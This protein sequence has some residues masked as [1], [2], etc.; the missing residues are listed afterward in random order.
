AHDI[1]L[2][3]YWKEGSILEEIKKPSLYGKMKNIKSLVC[4]IENTNKGGATTLG[5]LLLNFNGNTQNFITEQ[6]KLMRGFRRN[7]FHIPISD[8]NVGIYFI[9]QKLS[10]SRNIEEICEIYA[11]ERKINNWYVMI[12]GV[13]GL[14]DFIKLEFNNAHSE[15]LENEVKELRQF[16]FEQVTEIG[17]K[18]GRNDV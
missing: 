9:Q 17:K 3:Y 15:R 6:I 1:D 10:K 12:I 14:V 13:D 11:Y 2:Y 8:E 18:I 16:R 5:K 7:D 4:E